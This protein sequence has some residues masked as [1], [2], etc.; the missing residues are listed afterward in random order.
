MEFF[1]REETASDSDP[2]LNNTKRKI[3]KEKIPKDLSYTDLPPIEDLK[4]SVPEDE[5]EEI[6]TITNIVDI[7]VV[8]ES[9]KGSAPLDVDSILFLDKGSRTLGKVFDVIGPVAEPVYTVR[10]TNKD[11]IKKYQIEKGM[12]VFCAP[13]T[14]YAS[15]VF[16]PDLL[17]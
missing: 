3:K 8:V 17:K 5:C 14:D 13:R 2:E 11:Q 9:Y 1:S 16:L 4:I 15:Y 12:K 10:F 6:G 7:L